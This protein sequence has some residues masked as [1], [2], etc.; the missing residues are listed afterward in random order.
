MKRIV[1]TEVY[2]RERPR[3][4]CDSNQASGLRFDADEGAM[5]NW[6][7]IAYTD[8]ISRLV[9][10]AA[11]AV[12]P[13]TTLSEHYE[14]GIALGT[15]YGSQRLNEK[16]L[17]A[18]DSAGPRSVSANDFAINTYNSPAAL[19]AIRLGLRGPSIT[20]LTATGGLDAV[21]W[22]WQTLA[23]GK[24][25]TMIAGGYDEITP[26]LAAALYAGAPI[27]AAQPRHTF[28]ESVALLRLEC[29]DEMASGHNAKAA[30][31]GFGFA[32]LGGGG[33][34]ETAMRA[35]LDEARIRPG[36]LD[37]I[38]LSAVD[39]EGAEEE[40]DAIVRIFGHRSSLDIQGA[41][42]GYGLAGAPVEAAARAVTIINAR[43]ATG[44]RTTAL[45]NASGFS[46]GCSSLVLAE[47]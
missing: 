23:S 10:E 25:D 16:M 28:C 26:F 32:A 8:R 11:E 36:D 14:T 42:Q 27:V 3:V 7:D 21:D 39:A 38:Y 40:R 22:A 37:L 45:I 2:C 24:A 1:V 5:R 31:Q 29:A 15:V 19:A 20:L 35:A 12:L 9:I 41:D 17:F 43:A 18:I 34:R 30:L 33:T 47:P 6:H 4:A 46:S 44:Q 13:Q